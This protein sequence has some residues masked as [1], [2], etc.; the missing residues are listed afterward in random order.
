LP[1]FLKIL[2]WPGLRR[3]PQGVRVNNHQTGAAFAAAV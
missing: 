2:R 1:L 3:I